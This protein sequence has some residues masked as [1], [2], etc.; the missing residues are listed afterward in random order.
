MQWAAQ[1]IVVQLSGQAVAVY[2][3][4][5][6]GSRVSLMCQD[7]GCRSPTHTALIVV[8]IFLVVV[9]RIM[10]LNMVTHGPGITVVVTLYSYK[11]PASARS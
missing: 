2:V 9:I 5:I 6:F 4:L 10:F 3:F 8:A 7:D 1:C 11:K